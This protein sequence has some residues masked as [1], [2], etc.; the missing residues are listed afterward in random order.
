MPTASPSA[1][2]CTWHHLGLPP[3]RLYA[4]GL[5][6]G[7]GGLYADGH[8]LGIGLTNWAYCTLYADGIAL[9]V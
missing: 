9:G 3:D 7:V 2:R 6:L 4:D 5:T 8:A 1:Y